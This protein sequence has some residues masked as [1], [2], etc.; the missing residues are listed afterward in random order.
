M[1]RGHHGAARLVV[2]AG[3]DAGH[4]P[5]GA[6]AGAQVLAPCPHEQRC[7]LAPPDWCHFS[8]RLPRSRSHKHVKGADAPF[9]DERFSYVVLTRKPVAQR[10]SRVLAQ[11]S[12]GKAEITAKLCTANGLAIAKVPRRDK[13][14]Y[15]RARHWRWGDAVMEKS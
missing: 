7:P 1:G 3:R 4:R 5:Q 15:A 13:T 11:P 12:V 10:A 9:E 6:A 2:L 8:Q 14:A